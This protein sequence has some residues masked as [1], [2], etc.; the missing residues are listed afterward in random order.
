MEQKKKTTRLNGF[1]ECLLILGILNS[2][3]GIFLSIMN[4][5]QDEVTIAAGVYEIIARAAV[6]YFLIM[7][8]SAKKIGLYGYLA[9][10]VVNII[11]SFILCDGEYRIAFHQ[12]I[13]NAFQVAILFACLFF[14]KADG[15]SGWDVLFDNNT[16]NK[17][18]EAPVEK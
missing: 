12:M 17:E 14:L 8:S 5:C 9:M 10:V 7:L 6:I 16:I 4:I 13:V 11:A 2:G 15:V 3:L 18:G 1:T